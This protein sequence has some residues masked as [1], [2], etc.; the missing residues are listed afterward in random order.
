[1]NNTNSDKDV[2]ELRSLVKE[3]VH[4]CQS[5]QPFMNLSDR[6]LTNILE[7]D[8]VLVATYPITT[9][10]RDGVTKIANFAA[11]DIN[12][13]TMER[14]NEYFKLPALNRT[15]KEALSWLNEKVGALQKHGLDK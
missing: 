8:D 9:L 7:L 1:M 15:L 13:N 6:D 5:I 11:A 3:L 2:I 14:I 4:S 10:I 12:D